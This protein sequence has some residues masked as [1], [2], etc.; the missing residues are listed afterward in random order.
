MI[1]NSEALDCVEVPIAVTR[2]APRKKQPVGIA[3]Y[4]MPAQA[5]IHDFSPLCAAKSW[6]PACASMT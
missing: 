3:P 5:G 1:L 4:V 6:I 2:C